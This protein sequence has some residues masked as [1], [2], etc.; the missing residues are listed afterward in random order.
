M[1]VCP[2]TH[3]GSWRGRRPEA[4]G[5]RGADTLRNN[6][7]KA[8]SREQPSRH[9]HTDEQPHTA[10]PRT[11]LSCAHIA[12]QT[13][14]KFTRMRHANRKAAHGPS[15]RTAESTQQ[16]LTFRGSVARRSR[17]QHR[18]PRV[19][20]ALAGPRSHP[21]GSRRPRPGTGSVR[22]GSAEQV[23]GRDVQ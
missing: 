14:I 23:H 3:T 11:P 1:D 5:L 7:N 21:R 15:M 20:A 22:S 18:R 10:A 16:I 19:T 2:D 17:A 13:K 12:A 6:L 4:A 9:T 8:T